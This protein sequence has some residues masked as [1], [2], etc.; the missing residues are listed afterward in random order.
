[1]DQQIAQL[2]VGVAHIGTKNIF[3]K[4][5]V[6]LTPGRVFLKERSVLVPRT[7]KGAVVHG[8]ILAEGVEKRRQQVLFVATGCGFQL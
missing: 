2:H 7:G 4:E 5:I 8:H 1:M 6:K 3:T